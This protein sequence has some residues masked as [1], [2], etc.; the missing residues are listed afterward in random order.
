MKTGAGLPSG[1]YFDARTSGH[2][3]GHGRTTGHRRMLHQRDSLPG[4]CEQVWRLL[5]SSAARATGEV[6]RPAG[7]WSGREH[8][9]A[10]AAKLTPLRKTERSRSQ[11]RMSNSN[12]LRPSGVSE[13]GGAGAFRGGVALGWAHPESAIATDRSAVNL[14]IVGDDWNTEK[15]GEGQD[16]C[17]DRRLDVVSGENG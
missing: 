15:P 16:Y 7:W 6:I 9:A 17:G 1:A 4:H 12:V 3:S 13:S 5:L 2:L 14:G 8:G 11:E 10:C